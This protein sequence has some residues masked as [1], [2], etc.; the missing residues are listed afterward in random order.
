MN[1]ATLTNSGLATTGIVLICL[2]LTSCSNGQNFSEYPGFVAHFDKFPPKETG[3]TDSETEL[4]RQFKPQI[5]IAKGQRQPVD[6]YADYI[7]QGE[8]RVDGKKI[9][10]QVTSELL[11]EHRDNPRALFIFRGD[12]RKPGTPKVYARI[13]QE[14]TEHDGRQYQFTFL[15]YNLVFPVSG[16]LQGLGALQSFALTVGGNLNDWHQLDHY[17]GLSV[18]LLDGKAVAVTLQQH[19]YQTTYLLD[20]DQPV[21][22]A[23]VAMRSNELYPHNALQTK[24]PAVSFLS[25]DNLEFVMTDS[26]KPNLA[27]YD[28]THGE[29]QIEYDL[30][31]LPQT[32]AFYQFKGS[33]GKSRLLPGR[34]GPPGA[35]YVT[36]P[37]LMP[38]IN[39][40]VAAYRPGP[41]ADDIA[42]YTDLFD[43]DNFAIRPHAIKAYKDRFFGALK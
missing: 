43:R 14:Q 20:P 31:F 27:G 36:L 16:I 28:I 23:D 25:G 10:R 18:A 24:H 17:V 41:V 29:Q 19:N 11:N 26:N 35:D 12:Y 6:F 5:Y 9:S 38:R 1:F 4:L 2:A 21:I 33:L 7:S 34:S 40:L 13:D 37:G 15:S 3:P 32:D 22:A 39:R 42:L 8:L 30:V